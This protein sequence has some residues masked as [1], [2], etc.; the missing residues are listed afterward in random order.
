MNDSITEEYERIKTLV[1]R[2][3]GMLGLTTSVNERLEVRLTY[4]MSRVSEAKCLIKQ[5]SSVLGN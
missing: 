5:A 3:E 4:C 1:A 2:L